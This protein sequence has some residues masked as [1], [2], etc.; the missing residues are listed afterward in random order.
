MLGAGSLG[1]SR[2]RRLLGFRCLGA[3]SRFFPLSRLMG[4]RVAI[5][6]LVVAELE[7]GV[8]E[9]HYVAPTI[10]DPRSMVLRDAVIDWFTVV[11]MCA[12]MGLP[13][14]MSVIPSPFIALASSAD[15]V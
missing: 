1:R 4:R 12:A 5:S 8:F 10:F 14:T 2:C 6:E 7:L 9:C 15:V 11:V 13:S 3:P